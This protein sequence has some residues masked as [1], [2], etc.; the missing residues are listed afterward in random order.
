LLRTILDW[1]FGLDKLLPQLIADYGSWVYAILFAIIFAETGFVITPF[2]PG[3]SILF[4]A[5]AATASSSLSVHILVVVLIAAAILGDSTNYAIG[6]FVGPKVFAHAGQK[7]IWR[8]VRKSHLERTHDFF[9]KYGA[10]AIIIGRFVPI[11][12]TF[13]PF[14][15]GVGEMS[16]PKFLSYNIIGGIVWITLLVYA[17]HLFGNIPW[18]KVHFHWVVIGIIV[19]SVMPMVV[20]YL[21]ARYRARKN[22][23]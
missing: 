4:V 7:G 8:L 5:G 20:E 10:V 14:L 1:V 11:V 16:Y 21:K 6:R 2:L 9:E 3:D 22:L 12:R 13:A 18:V 15:A 17:G 19:V 23:A